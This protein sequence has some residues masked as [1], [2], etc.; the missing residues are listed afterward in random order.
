M[1]ETLTEGK[2]ENPFKAFCRLTQIW[3]DR[4]TGNKSKNIQI[5][6]HKIK[7]LHGRI[8]L[9]QYILP[10]MYK[11]SGSVSSPAK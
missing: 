11:T 2:E 6:L 10:D 3:Y 1:D 7:N 4:N 8:I 5:E 9:Q